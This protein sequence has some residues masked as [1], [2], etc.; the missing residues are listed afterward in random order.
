MVDSN[1]I[2]CKS[3]R[4]RAPA[5]SLF[6]YLGKVISIASR[7]PGPLPVPFRRYATRMQF[8]SELRVDERREIVGSA[9]DLG[10]RLRSGCSCLSNTGRLCAL[11]ELLAPRQ[12][13]ADTFVDLRAALELP[14]TCCLTRLRVFASVWSARHRARTLAENHRLTSSFTAAPVGVEG[15]SRDRA[16]GVRLETCVEGFKG[17]SPQPPLRL[18]R[19]RLENPSAAP[20][21]ERAH[22]SCCCQRPPASWR[23]SDSLD[24]NEVE[25]DRRQ[26]RQG[27]GSARDGP[28]CVTAC[29]PC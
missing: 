2:S 5:T 23:S 18:T 3:R 10:I 19:Y 14:A 11:D 15:V 7:I 8:A 16:R 27:Q 6:K 24:G 1:C 4:L 9:P 17:S 21:P 26:D 25:G 13:D 22:T 28:A 29:A 12:R 20:A